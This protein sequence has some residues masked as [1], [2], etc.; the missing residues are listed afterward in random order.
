V[1]R[2]PLAR[3]IAGGV[4]LGFIG[5]GLR[6]IV[7]H[8]GDTHPRQ[9]LEWLVGAAL[10]HDVLFAPLVAVAGFVVLRV[11]P[12]RARAAAQTGLVISGAV[13][14]VGLVA[15]TSPGR[16]HY[17]DNSSLLPLPYGRNLAIV[18]GAVWACC[19]VWAAIALLRR[20]TRQ[21]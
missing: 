17:S 11:V 19:A 16:R 3:L 8:A 12:R 13:L 7:V 5:I 18:L 6:G 1:S 20:P 14:A 2:V 4:G 10:V 9:W 15:L 21:R